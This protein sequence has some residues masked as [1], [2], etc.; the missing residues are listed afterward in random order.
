MRLVSWNVNG[1]RAVQRK[2][3]FDPFVEQLAPDVICM[4]EVKADHAQADCHLDGYDEF[5]HPAQ[6][7]GY[8]GTAILS[9]TVPLAVT[10]GLPGVLVKKFDLA[11]DPFGNPNDEGRVVTVE[12]DDFYLVT[13]YTPNAKGDLSRLASRHQK[14]DPAFLAYVT[15]LQKKKPVAICGDLNVAHTD[16]DLA[17][18]KENRGKAGYTDEERNGFEALLRAGFVDTFRMFTSGNG[19]YTWWSNFSGARARNVGWRIDYFLVSRALADKVTAA[20]IHADL[21]GSDHCP[22]SVT[23]DL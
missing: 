12:Y 13:A 22:V 1:I 4:Q 8:S 5:W 10:K 6:K 19:H 11:S 18:P 23:L 2:G 20:D 16:D 15:N 3:M 7:K 14:W 21:M 17:N 9:R